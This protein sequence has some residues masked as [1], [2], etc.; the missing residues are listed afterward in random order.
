MIVPDWFKSQ[1]ERLRGKSLYGDPVIRVVWGPDQRDWRGNYKYPHPDKN[2]P[3]ETWILERWQP[4]GFFGS[5]DRWDEGSNF[6]D[7]MKGKWV[8]IRGPF[9][10][11]G[12]YTMVAPIWDKVLDESVLT[13]IREKL[14]RDEEFA[15]LS[16]IERD[17]LVKA[18]DDRRQAQTME[19]AD[20]Q[21]ESLREYWLKNWDSFDRNVSRAYSGFPR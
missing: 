14:V 15:G 3:L 20:K 2:G 12:M 1:V 17:N 9:P 13:N 19:T 18:E 16:Q 10:S 21:Q 11:R 6:Y 7:D 5:K 8:N 4:A